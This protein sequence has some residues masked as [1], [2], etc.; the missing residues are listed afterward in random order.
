MEYHNE[1]ETQNHKSIKIKY[2][3]NYKKYEYK[4]SSTDN[5]FKNKNINNLHKIY[6]KFLIN[7][8]LIRNNRYHNALNSINKTHDDNYY[9]NNIQ[10]IKEKINEDN[11]KIELNE[12]DKLSNENNENKEEINNMKNINDLYKEKSDNEINLNKNIRSQFF[13][14]EKKN[15]LEQGYQQQYKSNPI[16]SKKNDSKE[17][18]FPKIKNNNYNIIERP[19][20]YNINY[21]DNYKD[22]YYTNNKNKLSLS[23]DVKNIKNISRNYYISPI[24]AKIAKH[25]YLMKNPYSDK[26][27][28]LGPS[29]LKNNPILYPIDTYK[30]DFNR[31]IRN[32]HVNKFV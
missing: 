28:Y 23:Y 22:L 14:E 21:S 16:T 18:I 1:Y 7:P 17:I 9:Y 24:I 29:F 8:Y 32:Y 15:M 5:I 20:E 30:F 6:N 12:P 26:D 4:H 31:Y 27:E 3:K 19:I 25:N 2:L 10:S 11:K 13:N